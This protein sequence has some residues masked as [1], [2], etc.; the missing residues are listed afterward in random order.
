LPLAALILVM[1]SGF[2]LAG[3][4]WLDLSVPQLQTLMFLVL[5][6]GGQGTVYL[7]RERGHLW[8]SRPSR[9]MLLGSIPDIAV[10]SVLAIWGILM[11]P[12]PWYV[13]LTTLAVVAVYL[14]M[15]DFFK[16]ALL[17]GPLG[18]VRTGRPAQPS[19]A[20]ART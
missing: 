15:M 11:S 13:V 3:R 17:R 9:W 7:V 5:V 10:V 20:A 18:E 8:A 2:F 1:S 4:A 12:L 14:L 6:F 19:G 16:L